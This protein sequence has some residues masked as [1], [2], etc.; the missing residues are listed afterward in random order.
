M[1]STSTTR[2]WASRL[3]TGRTKTFRLETR[4]HE[5]DARADHEAAGQGRHRPGVPGTPQAAARPGAPEASDARPSSENPADRDAEEPEVVRLRARD[6]RWR[7]AHV[8]AD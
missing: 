2:R 1:S 6:P 3:R 7:P 4:H 5:H 8:R